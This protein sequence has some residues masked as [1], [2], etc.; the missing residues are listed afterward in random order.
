MKDGSKG[1]ILEPDFEESWMSEREP[2]LDSLGS[3]ASLKKCEHFGIMRTM[4]SVELSV[5][6][7][8][9]WTGRTWGQ[10]ETDTEEAGG[11]G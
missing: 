9:L 5:L 11:L 7:C 8:E 4:M 2:G 10:K 1:N 3:G 6:P